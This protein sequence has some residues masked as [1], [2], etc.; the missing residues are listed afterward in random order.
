MSMTAGWDE[1]EFEAIFRKHQQRVVR[2][3]RRV[4]RRDSEAE[5]ICAEVFLRLYRSGPGV[6]AGGLVGGWLYRTASRAAIDALRAQ[7]RRGAREELETCA[8]SEDPAEGPLSQ[9]L[10]AERIAQVRSVLAQLKVDKA[11]ILLLRY[12]GLKYQEIAA[13]MRIRPASV[14]TMLA[15]AEAEFSRLYEQQQEPKN[16]SLFETVKE[17]R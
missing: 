12:G 15:R 2:L 1:T 17:R 10:R 11:Q 6:A 3:T 5:E 16:A 9:L 14:G 13:A 4:L 7:Q 8:Q